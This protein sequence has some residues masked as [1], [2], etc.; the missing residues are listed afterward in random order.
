[1]TPALVEAL[2]KAA[3]ELE[4]FGLEWPG[5]DGW[6]EQSAVFK[7]AAGDPALKDFQPA[8][9]V[10]WLV[11]HGHAVAISNE[12]IVPVTARERLLDELRGYFAR[13]SELS[14]GAF[15]ELSGLSRKLG[16]P[17]LEHLDQAGVTIRRQDVRVAGPVLEDS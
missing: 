5:L 6:V 13:E 1:M 14:F 16:I 4:A 12:Y 17:L 2:E 8:E 15:R 7:A 11:D 3:A 9:V 10:R